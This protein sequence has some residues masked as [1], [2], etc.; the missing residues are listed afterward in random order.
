MCA[1]TTIAR[2]ARDGTTSGP[3]SSSL[4]PAV[5]RMQWLLRLLMVWLI[6]MAT[7][8]ITAR[9]L[10]GFDVDGWRAVFGGVVAIGLLNA[11]LRPALLWLTL[12]LTA[13]TFGFST[14]LLNAVT[15]LLAG[16]LVPGLIVS[17]WFSALAATLALTAVN[18]ALGHLLALDDDDSFY[19]SMVRRHARGRA[20]APGADGLI[21]LEIDGL[22]RPAFERA[23]RD[24]HMPTLARWLAHG[25]HRVASWDCGMPSQTSSSQAGIL[26]GDSFDIPAFRWYEKEHG[27]LMVSSRPG[28]AAAVERRLARADAL[29]DDGGSSFCN[30][31][32]GGASRSVLTV[33][34]ISYLGPGVRQRAAELRAYFRNPYNF[35]RAV[36]LM[37]WELVVEWAGAARDRITG[38]TP[39]VSRGGTYPFMR[40]VSTI[41]LRDIAVHLLFEDIFAGV[42]TSYTTFGGYDVVAHY[43]GVERADAL[44]VLRGIDNRIAQVERVAA[45]AERRYRLVVLSDH[46]QSQGASF[47]QRYGLALEDLVLALPHGAEHVHASVG[48]DESRGH[49]DALIAEAL[50]LSRRAD[51][52]RQEARGRPRAREELVEV[53]AI[54][55][56]PGESAKDIVVCAS[57]NLG[58]VYF[59]AWRDR[60][61]LE[62]IVVRYPGLLDGL[63]GHEGIGFVLVR[64]TR[65]GPV[66]L[67]RNGQHHVATGVIVGDDPLAPFGSRA[68]QH[69]LRLDS[70]PH[71]GDLVI[72]SLVAADG[73]VA[74]FE[75]Q[76]GSH[77]GLGGPQTDAF[78]M[79]PAELPLEDDTT[80][81]GPE[82]INRLLREWSTSEHRAA[83]TRERSARA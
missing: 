48:S 29:L 24:G 34:T 83:G 52:A 20:A 61:S 41:L 43:A 38:V 47:R 13:L 71:V 12:P 33:S 15:I 56:A 26:W 76:V 3:V 36:V 80:I 22:S 69:L 64:S 7:L 67:G 25:T 11:V 77:G 18:M 54:A 1:A 63:V 19:R 27:R 40:A 42:P 70:F 9:M 74:A 68:R 81:V 45:R 30:M 23:L 53:G 4:V 28:D 16:W 5:V 14:L 65:H 57:G 32:S 44:R 58:L 60:A 10:P 35:S 78:I 51:E 66:A 75:E 55:Q 6:E 31:F 82:A 46:G 50:P 39:R 59:T 73:S 2:S 37:L 72:N 49:L 79:F 62:E 8:A 17:G 21:V